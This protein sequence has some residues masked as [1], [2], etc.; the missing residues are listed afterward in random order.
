MR[1]EDETIFRAFRKIDSLTRASCQL[2]FLQLP[3]LLLA[4]AR[5]VERYVYE[6]RLNFSFLKNSYRTKELVALLFL[7]R[8]KTL[9]L[10]VSQRLIYSPKS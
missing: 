8:N 9:N 2:H 4:L 6:D 7:V 5:L 3:V 1:G 10:Q